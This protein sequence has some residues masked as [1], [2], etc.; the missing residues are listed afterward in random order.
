MTEKYIVTPATANQIMEA[1]DITEEEKE[2]AEYILSLDSVKGFDEM[3]NPS[4]IV[5]CPCGNKFVATGR[6]VCEPCHRAKKIERSIHNAKLRE[7]KRKEKLEA[8]LSKR[9]RGK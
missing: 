2:L 5:T 6:L 3:T 9:H 7:A 4:Y 1:M 8:K